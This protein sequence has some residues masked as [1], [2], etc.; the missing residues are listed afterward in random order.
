MDETTHVH[1]LPP[2]DWPSTAR[3]GAFGEQAA[4]RH[5]TECDGL[6]LLARNWRVAA[7]ELRG[8]LDLV[9]LDERAGCLVVAEVKTRRDASRLGG[10]VGALSPRKRQRV[11]RLTAAF[12]HDSGLRVGRVRLDAVAVDLAPSPRLT[13]L[14]AAL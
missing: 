11:R 14:V 13:H 8:E 6:R 2:G 12:L 7:G 1:P 4:A 9:A 3:L 5:L 10:A